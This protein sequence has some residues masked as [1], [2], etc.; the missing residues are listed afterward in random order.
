MPSCSADQSDR[1]DEDHSRNGS[2]EWPEAV[3]AV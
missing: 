3:P 2:V 1:A